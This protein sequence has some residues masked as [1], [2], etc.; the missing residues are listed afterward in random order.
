MFGIHGPDQHHGSMRRPKNKDPKDSN[1][2]SSKYKRH[3]KLNIPMNATNGYKN[4]EHVWHG[5]CKYNF[6]R[7]CPD[8]KSVNLSKIEGGKKMFEKTFGNVE[9]EYKVDERHL[10]FKEH[11]SNALEWGGHIV[12]ITSKAEQAFVY[13]LIKNSVRQHIWIGGMRR[14][15]SNGKGSKYWKWSA[16][17]NK[18]KGRTWWSMFGRKENSDTVYPW[19]YENWARGEPNNWGGGEDRVQMWHHNGQ[20]NDCNQH[21]RM[22]A[23]WKRVKPTRKDLRRQDAQIE[24]AAMEKERMEKERVEKERMEKEQ[25]EKERELV[26]QEIERSIQ[27]GEKLCA[28]FFNDMAKLFERLHV[29]KTLAEIEEK[30]VLLKR[31]NKLK[32]PVVLDIIQMI[33]KQQD[34]RSL[35]KTVFNKNDNVGS[36]ENRKNTTSDSEIVYSIA[37]NVDD[38]IAEIK[39][40]QKISSVSGQ[41]S[42]YAGSIG[43]WTPT[44]E[45]KRVK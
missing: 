2:F 11:E 15:K 43:K 29:Q 37:K 25:M 8:H 9:Y 42:Q 3:S 18:A 12:S 40:L 26:M 5:R 17:A 6:Y 38:T 10:N 20:W 24:T 13:N 27:A 32:E 36:N 22:A 4:D 23:V 34:I 39:K 45:F 44:V 19:K 33:K 41:F 16:E 28:S 31:S 35:G 21:A 1:W 14:G 7:I 30:K